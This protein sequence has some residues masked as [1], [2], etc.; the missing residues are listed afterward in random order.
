[1]NITVL[2]YCIYLRLYQLVTTSWFVGTTTYTLTLFCSIIFFID[3]TRLRENSL[4]YVTLPYITYLSCPFFKSRTMVPHSRKICENR[5]L[6]TIK[7]SVRASSADTHTESLMWRWRRFKIVGSWSQW[8]I[9]L[10]MYRW[11]WKFGILFFVF[12]QISL[13]AIFGIFWGGLDFFDPFKISLEM[14]IE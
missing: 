4:F 13:W 2:L 14:A 9:K 1:M 7:L 6:S 8:D 5:N 3:L 12:V 10:S 11:F